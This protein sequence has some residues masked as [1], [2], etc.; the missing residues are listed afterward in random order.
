MAC[1]GESWWL[2]IST[3]SHFFH[4]TVLRPNESHS[5]PPN[6]FTNSPNSQ[7]S[8]R[9]L[10]YQLVYSPSWFKYIARALQRIVH[11]RVLQRQ[12]VVG[13]EFFCDGHRTRGSR[14]HSAALGRDEQVTS[15]VNA[16]PNSSAIHTRP[17]STILASLSRS[18]AAVTTP[19]QHPSSKV[20]P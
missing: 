19:F 11:G 20:R 4:F 15:L 13:G 17:P 3:K 1:T 8:Q 10:C 12:G 16:Q 14:R 5:A 2:I 18:F 6:R 7:F 9:M